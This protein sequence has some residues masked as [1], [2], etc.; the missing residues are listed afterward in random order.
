MKLYKLWI[1]HYDYDQFDSMVVAAESEEEAK[2]I[3]PIETLILPG[4]PPV[5]VPV[6]VEDWPTLETWASHPSLVLSEYLGEA[7][8]GTKCGIIC[9][10]YNES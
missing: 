5:R 6:K 4:P 1:E 10:S 9:A 3:H 7:K 8:P 2:C